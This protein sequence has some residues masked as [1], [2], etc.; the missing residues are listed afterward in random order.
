M[1][2]K[3]TNTHLCSK[4]RKM[5]LRTQMGIL[6]ISKHD[7][8]KGSS[9]VVNRGNVFCLETLGGLRATSSNWE[10]SDR[11]CVLVRAFIAMTKCHTKNIV[12]WEE[13]IYW[14]TLPMSQFVTGGNHDS[15]SNS[16]NLQAG[17]GAVALGGGAACWLAPHGLL[18]LLSHRTQDH[19]PRMA[20][21]TV[22]RTLP[23]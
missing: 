14:L 4:E 7:D 11:A 12:T 17:T 16:K 15:N 18:S 9:R 2:H 5:H 21:P 22:G 6:Y 3:G 13:R 8:P 23:H 19:Q 20:P 1:Q 10:L